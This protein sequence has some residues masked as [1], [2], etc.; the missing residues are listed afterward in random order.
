MKHS[1]QAS[2]TEPS[3]QIG[4]FYLREIKLTAI[5]VIPELLFL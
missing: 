3:S 2:V 4:L 1:Q 5:K